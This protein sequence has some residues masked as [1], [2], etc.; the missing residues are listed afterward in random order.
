[1]FY[2]SEKNINPD[3]EI[4]TLKWI[5]SINKRFPDNSFNPEPTGITSQVSKNWFLNEI[6]AE[7]ITYEVG[8]NTPRDIIN[9]RGKEAAKQL[10][11]IMLKDI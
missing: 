6:K 10:M 1:I 9:K 7:S 8:D 11:K 2:Y 4:I 5:N 3:K